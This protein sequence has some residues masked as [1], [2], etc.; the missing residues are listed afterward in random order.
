MHVCV[1]RPEVNSRYL[2]QSLPH[3]T[4]LRHTLSLNHLA[5]LAIIPNPRDRPVSASPG[6]CHHTSF[7]FFVVCLFACFVCFDFD[8]FE[9]VSL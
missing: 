5:T 3:L 9:K 2:P 1:Q 7:L 6:T 8:F 4:F